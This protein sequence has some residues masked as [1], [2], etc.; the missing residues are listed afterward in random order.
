MTV[1]ELIEQ[2]SKEVRLSRETILE[3]LKREKHRTGDLISDVALLQIIAAELGLKI[4]SNE[5]FE[6]T[7][8]ISDL[9]PNLSNVTVVGRI[10][11]VF[12]PKTF[13][14]HR[15]GRFASLLVAD[16]SDVVRV[17]F[18]NDKTSFLES[19]GMKVGQV[20][21]FSHGYT[22]EDRGGRVEVH[23]GERSEI[24]VEPTDVQA[25]DYPTISNFTMK[26][27]EIAASEKNGKINL[28]GTVKDVSSTS[29]FTRQDSTCGKVLR[30]TL[31]DKSGEVSVVF[32][33][34]K[35]DEL[36]KSLRKDM[37]LQLVSAK[38]RKSMC[39]GLEV[40]VDG[41]SYVEVVPPKVEFLVV[42]D[43]KG[44]LSEVNVRGEVATKP[45]VRE[46]RTGK[47]ELVKLAVFE[48]KDKTGAIWVSAW[49]KHAEIVG[50]LRVGDRVVVKNAF[51]KKG[52]SD[53]LE[54]STRDATSIVSFSEGNVEK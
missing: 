12:P 43:L 37:R 41:G 44:V 32:W 28:A 47:G 48:L 33:N 5:V 18:W 36:E 3:K 21:R 26:I 2:L 1:D 7:L 53:A 42:A 34:E 11:A 52:F 38:V 25:K 50:A 19:G 4:R 6:P 35:V 24:T 13:N 46:V 39:G 22:K 27:A 16:K 8:L 20:V 54:I 15:N 51:A 31:A 14:G 10:V 23:I 49:R 29:T 9:V 17:V 30:L 45:L 40:H